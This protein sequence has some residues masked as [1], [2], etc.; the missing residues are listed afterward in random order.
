[1]ETLYSCGCSRRQ[2]II[3]SMDGGRQYS[4]IL[5]DIPSYEEVYWMGTRPEIQVVVD[6]KTG[7]QDWAEDHISCNC[8]QYMYM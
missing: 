1:M 8:S 7:A 5:L 4:V 2:A 3:N 6:S